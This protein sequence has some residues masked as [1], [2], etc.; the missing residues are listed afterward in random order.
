MHSVQ[1]DDDFPAEE[2]AEEIH[3]PVPVPHDEVAAAAVVP[4]QKDVAVQIGKRV[5]DQLSVA[6]R[7]VEAGAGSNR[8]RDGWRA[9][10]QEER[11][12]DPVIP[13]SRFKSFAK[14][15]L[16]EQLQQH[17]LEPDALKLGQ[18][19]LHML[20][21][22][23]EAACEHFMQ[24]SAMLAEHA[25][26]VTIHATDLRTVV[27][28]RRRWG[29]PLFSRQKPA[30]PADEASSS[31]SKPSKSTVSTKTQTKQFWLEAE[32]LP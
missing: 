22:F 19:A 16:A 31:Q 10:R 11:S 3:E 24:D 12:V 26:R 23:I 4:P 5:E 21:V 13:Q 6:R 25:H 18:D 2:L 32:P 27:A 14:E 15:V 29:D 1:D 8:A 28:L 7:L 20:Q 17:G 9:M 30:T